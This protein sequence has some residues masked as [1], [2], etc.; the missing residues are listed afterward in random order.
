[1]LAWRKS[2]PNGGQA[3]LER[4]TGYSQYWYFWNCL[5]DFF[6]FFYRNNGPN[7]CADIGWQK[8]KTTLPMSELARWKNCSASWG[9]PVRDWNISALLYITAPK[10]LWIWG[11]I[12]K[13][14]K[15]IQ[16]ITSQDFIEWGLATRSAQTLL[17]LQEPLCMMMQRDLEPECPW[18]CWFRKWS[19]ARRLSSDEIVGQ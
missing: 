2:W 6:F 14:L 7:A 13:L 1:M 4:Y 12:R 3:S 9:S 15:S 5:L 19:V 16:S 11:M 18:L 8:G 10:I 17:T